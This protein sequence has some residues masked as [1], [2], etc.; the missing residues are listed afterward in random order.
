MVITIGVALEKKVAE[1]FAQ[2]MGIEAFVLDSV[3]SAMALSI[4]NE[5]AQKILQETT[6][7]DWQTGFCLRPG[8]SYWDITGQRAVFRI[9]PA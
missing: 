1:L 7:R 8:E 9:V 3:G 4:F 6:A 2:D 5:A